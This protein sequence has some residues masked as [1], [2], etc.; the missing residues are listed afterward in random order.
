MSQR[1]RRQERP[2][3]GLVRSGR[4]LCGDEILLCDAD[5]RRDRKVDLCECNSD[6]R[7]EFP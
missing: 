2:S 3:R 4:P 6:R 1:L 7:P 5:G